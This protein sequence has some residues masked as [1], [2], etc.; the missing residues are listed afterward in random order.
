MAGS[1]VLGLELFTGYMLNNWW[2]LFCYV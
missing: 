1:S 2:F